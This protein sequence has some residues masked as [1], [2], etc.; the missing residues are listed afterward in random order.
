MWPMRVLACLGILLG[1]ASSTG[2]EP[3]FHG[4]L[5]NFQRSGRYVLFVN[6]K[7]EPKARVYHSRRGSAFLVLAAALR[8]P[9]LLRA[10]SKRVERVPEDAVLQGY[11]DVIDLRAD[12][13]LECVGCLRIEG[14]DVAFE[15]GE[16]PAR[17]KPKPPLTGKRTADEVREHSPEMAREGASY[18]PDSEAVRWLAERPEP[19]RLQVFFGNWCALCH[20]VVPRLLK[21]EEALRE[22]KFRI[23]FYGLPKPPAAWKDPVY[24]KT[25]LKALPT[26]LVLVDDEEVARIT[27][28]QWSRPE[29]TLKKL[30]DK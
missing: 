9:I 4:V 23:E 8:S 25:G 10:R 27:A 17:L 11:D 18:K 16:Q 1:L 21:L 19:T 13:C 2:A 12:V 29:R 28:H 5:R 7:A 14:M 3:A 26:G 15:V 30:L 20:R 6:G 24:V 22:S